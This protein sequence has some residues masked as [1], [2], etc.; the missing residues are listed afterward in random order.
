MVPQPD[1]PRLASPLPPIVNRIHTESAHPWRST[2][3]AVGCEGHASCDR[4]FFTCE[5]SSRH[6]RQRMT[7]MP[8]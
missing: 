2:K 5:V 3:N 4:H 1:V 8:L 6:D 7:A